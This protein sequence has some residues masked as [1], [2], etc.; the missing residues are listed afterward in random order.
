MP[1]PTE[2]INTCRQR[3]ASFKEEQK[4]DFADG[5]DITTLLNQAS[6]TIDEVLIQLWQHF[7]PN[8]NPKDSASLIATGGYGRGE[9]HPGSDIDLM[10]LLPKKY[11]KA[12][13]NGL[14]EFLTVLWDI[15]L[16][17]GHSV[18]TLKETIS[19]CKSDITIATCLQEARLINGDTE[20][21]ST[22]LEAT[23]PKKIWPSKKFFQA[24]F[25]EQHVRHHRYRDTAYNLEPNV[26][27]NIGGIRDIQ[28]IAWV[29][30]RHFDADTINEL[31]GLG[32][33]TQQ[34]FDELHA[35]KLFLWKIRF[36]LHSLNN[37]R[38][39]RLLFDSQIKIAEQFGYLGT[40][41]RRPV[42]LFMRDYYRSALTVSRL[43]WML[44]QLFREHILETKKPNIKKIDA[45][46]QIRNDYLDIVSEDVFENDHSLILRLFSVWQKNVDLRGITA[47]TNRKLHEALDCIDDD[48]RNNAEHKQI[49]LDLFNTPVKIYN[50]L[51]RMNRHGVLGRFMPSFGDIVGHM[52]FDMFHAYTVD[53]H[54]LFVIKE[55]ENLLTQK[56]DDELINELVASLSK[57]N[58][59]ILSGLF[60]DIAKGRGG[61]HSTLGAADVLAFGK[62]FGLKEKDIELLSFLVDRHLVLSVTAQKKDIDDPA[63]ISEFADIADN[64][65]K[66]KYLYLLTIADVKGTNPELWNQ[67]KAVLFAKLYKYTLNHFENLSPN[68]EE[69]LQS[70]KKA[71]LKQLSK[72]YPVEDIKKTWALID[73]EYFIRHSPGEIRWH[74]RVLQE[75]AKL[76]I[77]AIRKQRTGHLSSY[78]ENKAL[79][80]FVANVNDSQLFTK[81][82]VALDDLNLDIYNAKLYR[83]KKLINSQDTI[84]LTFRVREGNRDVLI[85]DNR[86][87]QI[88]QT[89]T[90]VLNSDEKYR[91][92]AP[93]VT[94]QMRVFSS[95]T[96]V[97]FGTD[98]SDTYTTIE[99][100][101]LDRQGLLA[102]IG[103]CFAESGINITLAK[104]TTI[105]E[106]AEDV[107]YISDN[108]QQKLNPE[109]QANIEKRIREILD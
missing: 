14:S 102:M 46:L 37:G 41:S 90:A 34:E 85:N 44:L 73:D 19:A 109:Q 82:C 43:N 9:L 38:E 4:Q 35:A 105:G 45:Q 33:L 80:L 42:E 2:L 12:L 100:D 7:V 11:P 3:I 103:Y 88:H 101:T 62:N 30:K 8:T 68:T 59:L 107:F 84:A 6:N 60:H 72:E 91:L 32:F 17:V 49:F 74:T 79:D 81:V 98:P 23:G 70:K 65:R 53:A 13:E 104:I 10:I 83:N 94:R 39:D 27:G 22:M 1:Y 5:A 96:K 69:H 58:I 75:Q 93:K 16:E 106:R 63:V 92:P 18:R 64:K 52:Q 86:K 15:G 87:E 31:V 99:L 25:D 71:A 36:A 47:R 54:I 56:H 29:L 50:T 95:P 21:F 40:E 24:K 77:I 76:P 78:N 97:T 61:D 66:L 28:V 48:F 51:A 55:I 89:I 57:P 108:K 20:Q 67:W 26:K